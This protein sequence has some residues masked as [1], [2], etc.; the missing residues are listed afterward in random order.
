MIQGSFAIGR[1]PAK[2]RF[3]GKLGEGGAAEVFVGVTDQAPGFR[4]LLVL[5]LLRAELAEEA[6]HVTMFLD[7]ARLA[8][9]LNHRNVVQTYEVG[10]IGERHAIVMEFLE[11]ASL[12]RLRRLA[13]ARHGRGRLP[14]AESI[15]IMVEALGG[16]H[17]AHQ[18]RDFDGT[19]LHFVHRD[20]TPANVMVTLDGQVK[21]LDFG[22]AKTCASLVQ[23]RTGVIKGTTRY[24][25]P[26]AVRGARVDRRSDVYMAGAVLWQLV[27]GQVPWHDLPEMGVMLAIAKERLK[28]IRAV[29]DRLP[30]VLEMIILRA[31]DP[32]RSARFASALE[33]RD[34]LVRFA[35][36]TGLFSNA[37]RLAALAQELAGDDCQLLSRRIH[38]QLAK[39]GLS[40]ESLRASMAPTLPV[41]S[42]PGAGA[43]VRANTTRVPPLAAPPK[44]IWP[45]VAGGL[46]VVSGALSAARWQVTE[47]L[48]ARLSIDSPRGTEL[49]RL[50]RPAATKPGPELAHDTNSTAFSLPVQQDSKP[51][52]ISLAIAAE[53]KPAGNG[54][55]DPVLTQGERDKPTSAK[56]RPRPALRRRVRP[57][58]SSPLAGTAKAGFKERPAAKKYGPVRRTQMK[59]RRPLKAPPATQPPPPSRSS[60]TAPFLSGMK[61]SPY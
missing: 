5:K 29:D 44:R 40:P 11:G 3:L 21:V 18:L 4:K 38:R 12:S 7:E 53:G 35:R 60:D 13:Q 20:F 37:D 14:L 27:T 58:A 55:L 34:A 61:D 47:A 36:N 8:A 19:E 28:P 26:E 31:T 57:E 16:L 6:E 23:T 41:A 39:E 2:Y 43:H 49:E 15:H 17:Y 1:A 10:Q 52:V 54:A 45:W 48:A 51:T 50:V 24:L 59:L 9:R 25:S 30:Q 42:Q 56:Q 32:D 33:L 46:L 22:I